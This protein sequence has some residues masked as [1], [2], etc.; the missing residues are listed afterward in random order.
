[1]GV[2]HQEGSGSAEHGRGVGVPQAEGICDSGK[3]RE[4]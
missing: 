3:V 2:L 4:M 1:M